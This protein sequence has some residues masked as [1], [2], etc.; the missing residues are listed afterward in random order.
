MK[1]QDSF[2]RELLDRPVG[3]RIAYFESYTM[4]HPK[5]VEAAQKLMHAIEEPAGAPLVFIFGPTGV[6]KSTL[7]RRVTQ[8]ITE[9]LLTE[10]KVDKGRIPIAGI[11]AV[12]PEF[13]NFDW[14]DFY[15]RA[16]E[17]LN[18]PVLGGCN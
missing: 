10:L 16:F 7:L 9:A 4:A 11:E 12:A 14:K 1:P 13:S 17:A 5:L 15:V 3:Q 2:P 18:A 6:G 8:K